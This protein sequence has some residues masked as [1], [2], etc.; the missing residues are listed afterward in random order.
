MEVNTMRRIDQRARG[1]MHK[2]LQLTRWAVF[3]LCFLGPIPVLRAA[4]P[5]QNMF[6]S[7][8][9]A[10]SALVR[11]AQTDDLS[12]LINM[13]GA[14]AKD[15]LFSGDAAEDKNRRAQFVRKYEE[16][17]RVVEEPDG[18]VRLYIGAEN[19]P[20]P[21]PLVKKGAG[22]NFDARA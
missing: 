21:V 1:S 2:S 3:A 20:M 16:M 6:A 13:F 17:H 18:T 7:P 15:I 11:A 10:S 5:A 14:D 19:W 9:E 8:A 22:W 12:A 4:P